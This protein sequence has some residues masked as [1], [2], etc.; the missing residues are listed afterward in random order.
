LSLIDLPIVLAA[1]AN[2]YT[3]E[4]PAT[5]SAYRTQMVDAFMDLFK[6]FGI[7]LKDCF[8]E[9]FLIN[10]PDCKDDKV[11]LGEVQIQDNKTFKICNFTKRRYV[12][13]VQLMEYWLSTIPILPIIKTALAEFCCKVI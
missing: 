12:K 11:Y 4:P 8:C 13:S 7:Y 1:P 5:L 9:Q 2:T 3:A 6:T 10:C